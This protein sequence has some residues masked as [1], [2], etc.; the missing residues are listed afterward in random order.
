MSDKPV[1]SVNDL[2]V[3]YPISGGLLTPKVVVRAVEGVTLDI[4]RGSFFGLV[5]GTTGGDVPPCQFKI[6]VSCMYF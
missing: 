2:A 6:R 4:P 3:H 1:I 5:G